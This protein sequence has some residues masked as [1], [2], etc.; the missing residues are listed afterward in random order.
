M[1]RNEAILDLGRP[2]VDALH[3]LDL[4]TSVDAPAARLAYLVVVTQAG[5]QFAL[6]FTTRVQVDRVVD[7]LVRDRFVGVVGPHATQY[8]RNLLRR[9]IRMLK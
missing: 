1:A 3:V 8:V 4:A 7:R 5:D 6:E 9:Q 2:D